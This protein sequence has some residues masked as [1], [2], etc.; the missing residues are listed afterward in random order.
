MSNPGVLPEDEVTV[1]ANRL[2]EGFN[3]STF[4]CMIHNS[5][6]IT[7]PNIKWTLIFPSM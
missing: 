2:S 5:F 7:I 1:S 3:I 6:K 4:K